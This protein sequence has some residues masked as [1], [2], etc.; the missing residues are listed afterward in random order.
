[1]YNRI[2]HRILTYFVEGSIAAWMTSSFTGL[3]SPA[4]LCK[5]I[6]KFIGL[7]ESK[8]V[9]NGVSTTVILPLTM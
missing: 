3:D 8:P 1:M 6:N 2:G 4:L 5:I 9:E 7:V